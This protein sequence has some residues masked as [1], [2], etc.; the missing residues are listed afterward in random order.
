MAILRGIGLILRFIW[1]AIDGVRKVLHLVLLLCL[2]A[3]FIA[4]TNPTIP[5][6]PEKAA[7]VIAPEGT[8]VEELLIDVNVFKVGEYK[9][10]PDEFVRKDMSPEE[11][12]ESS[13][14]LGDLWAQYQ[15]DVGKRRKLPAGALTSYA[16]DFATTLKSAGGDTAKVAL[17]VGLVTGI[18]TRPAVEGIL[19]GFVGEDEATHSFNQVSVDEY[20]QATRAEPVLGKH[21]DNK[22]AIIVASG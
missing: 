20:L 7:L 22:V 18:E 6:V 12:E 4:A 17:N 8:L 9:S 13:V 2:L 14:W 15:A 10:A 5:L 3:I 16:N 21:S 11:R 19:K 1:R